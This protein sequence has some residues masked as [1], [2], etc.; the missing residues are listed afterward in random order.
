MQ[1]RPEKSY[2]SN[3]SFFFTDFLDIRMKQSIYW[4]S[5]I[6]ETE[7]DTNGHKE[8]KCQYECLH[9]NIKNKWSTELLDESW[10]FC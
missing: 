5:L 3:N 7:M 10:T 1:R 4:K 2:L 8:H 6:P 9:H